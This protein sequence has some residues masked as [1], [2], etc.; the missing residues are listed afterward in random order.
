MIAIKARF[1]K[2]MIAI[3]L[4]PFKLNKANTKNIKTTLNNAN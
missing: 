3:V 4:I 1:I 2:A